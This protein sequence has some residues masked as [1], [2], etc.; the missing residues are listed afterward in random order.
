MIITI[1]QTTNRITSSE[2]HEELS[3]MHNKVCTSSDY[4]TNPCKKPRAAIQFDPVYA[5]FE[6]SKVEAIQS[7]VRDLSV[8][9]GRVQPSKSV[10]ELSEM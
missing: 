7:K 3:T 5:V 10:R 6:S 8:H 9:Q 2:L 1:S 4:Y